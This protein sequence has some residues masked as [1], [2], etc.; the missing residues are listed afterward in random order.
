MKF[1]PIESCNKI[2]ECC[3]GSRFAYEPFPLQRTCSW[4][5]ETLFQL[6][7]HQK[8]ISLYEHEA[9]TDVTYDCV[10]KQE[11]KYFVSELLVRDS[12]V[13]TSTVFEHFSFPTV[14]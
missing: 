11:L 3:N 2:I 12:E 13:S 1:F 9:L 14:Q 7:K 6:S 5:K 4:E 8:N 10:L